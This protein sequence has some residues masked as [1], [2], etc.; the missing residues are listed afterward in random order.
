M[1]SPRKVYQYS[2]VIHFHIFSLFTL[3]CM[4]CLYYWQHAAIGC[5]YNHQIRPQFCTCHDSSAVMTTLWPDAIIKIIIMMTS[6]NG[7]IFHVTGL[8]CRVFTGLRWIPLTKASDGAFDVSYD[9]HLNKQLSKQSSRWWFETPSGPLW[10]HCNV[11][12][13]PV[14]TIF[15]S[16]VHKQMRGAI[17]LGAIRV[18]MFIHDAA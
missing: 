15:Q 13:N 3:I 12:G 8:L 7:A 10:R 2:V 5:S 4:G 17:G 6:S 11:M 9:L 18:L 16:W 14:V 1:I